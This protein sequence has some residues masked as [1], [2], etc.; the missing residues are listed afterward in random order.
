[1]VTFLFAFATNDFFDLHKLLFQF[2]IR[3]TLFFQFPVQ[4]LNRRQRHAVGVH[5]GE[6]SGSSSSAAVSMN[7]N[8]NLV[9]TERLFAGMRADLIKQMRG[10]SC[11]GRAGN[12]L[13]FKSF[14]VLAIPGLI[15][16]PQSTVAGEM[17]KTLNSSTGGNAMVCSRTNDSFGRAAA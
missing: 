16:E 9:F 12:N 6:V 10:A 7:G 3:G 17:E 8:A 5:G 1:M 11:S 2:C 4:P 14:A 13:W 15:R